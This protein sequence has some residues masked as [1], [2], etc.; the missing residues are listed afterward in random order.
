MA[1]GTS[2]SKPLSPEQ[3]QGYYNKAVELFGTGPNSPLAGFQG[4]GPAATSSTYSASNKSAA[5]SQ[6]G[7]AAQA[8][9][10]GADTTDWRSTDAA[11]GNYDPAAQSGFVDPGKAQQLSG[12]NYDALQAAI[13]DPQARDIAERQ[14]L[15]SQAV[16]EDLA[17]R[18]IFT[19][20][21]GVQA[22]NDVA[23]EFERQRQDAASNAAA[24]RY[25]LQAGDVAQANQ[26]ALGRS[27]QGNQSNQF[28]ADAINRLNEL[29]F[30]RGTD[31]NLANAAGRNTAA[32]QNAAAANTT[33]L[34]NSQ[35]ANQT[36]QFNAQGA[37]DVAAANQSAVNAQNQFNAAQANQT[38]QFNAA[39]KTANSQFNAGQQ[40]QVSQQNAAAQNAYNVDAYQ[41]PFNQYMSKIAAFYGGQQPTATSKQGNLW[42][43]LG[44]N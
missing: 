9:F 5:T 27:A 19:S 31:V 32:S 17:R 44:L 14:G 16:N 29:V 18:G 2:N 26:Y 24:L 38:S 21:A 40:N 37:R 34:Q 36:S 43:W 6:Q 42:S 35:Q 7:P 28:N 12:G 23:K 8:D 1:K 4:A 13:F 11:I 33:S 15:A 20:G 30:G 22:S 41:L 10:T 39:N 3:L 25:N